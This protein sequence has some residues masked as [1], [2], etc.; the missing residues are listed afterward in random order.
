MRKLT[1][2]T[3]FLV[4]AAALFMAAPGKGLAQSL[5]LSPNQNPILLTI[6]GPGGT[7]AATYSVSA[8]NG[9]AVSSVFV[10]PI[11]TTTG[12]SWLSTSTPGTING[13][14]FTLN[15][16]NTTNLAPN[17]SYQGTVGVTASTTTGNITTTFP[18][19]L[20]IGNT[21]GQPGT[22]NG[23]L[24]NPS[25]I[26]F[27]ETAPGQASPSSQVVSVTLNG[28]QV[29]ITSVNFVTSPITTPTFINTQLNMQ[30]GTVTVTPNSV[31]TAAGTY[32]GTLTAYTASG[33]LPIPVVLCFGP[34]APTGGTGN[35][36]TATPN[37]L[38]F[39][40]QTGGSTAPQTVNINFNGAATNINSVTA[41]TNTGG[42]WL[43]P[44]STLPGT[45][46]VGVNA[47]GLTAGTYAG[48]VFVN[49]PQGQ[50]TIPVS[51]TVSG[52][53]SLT[54]TP[55][56]VNFAYQLGTNNPLSQTV[57]IASNGSAVSY[58]VSSTTTT[59][60]SQWLIVSPSGQGATPGTLTVSVQPSGLA[61]GS[62]YTG[63]IQ[64]NTFGGA[65]NGTI[66][67]PVSLLVSAS[68]I[69]AVNPTSLSFTAQAGATAPSQTFQITS[70]STALNYT[71]NASVTTPPAGTW[72]QVAT[73][74]G[75]TPSTVTVAVNTAGLAAGTYSGAI[76]ITSTN[77]GNGSVLV[78]V[79]LT[80]SAGAALQLTPGTLSFAY[81]LG[82]A[83]PANQSVT[84]ASQTGILGYTTAV[85]T[86]SGQN[87]LTVSPTTGTAP[88]NFVVSVVPAG[89]TA[90]TY[91]GTITVT[92]SGS[93]NAP[94][95]IPVTLVVS[96]T[97]LLLA[98]PNFV[99]FTAPQG[100]STSSFQ[101]VA[102]TSTD[103]T[104]IAF[105]VTSTTNSAANWLL[106]STSTG[107]TPANLTI[108]ANP[109]GL[110]P[111]T[112]TGTVTLTATT[113]ANVANSPQGITVTLVVT[114]TA[115][116]AVSQPTLSFTQ[117]TSGPAP[118]SQTVSVTSVGN[119]ITF[120]TNATVTA[121]GNWLSVTPINATTPAILTVTANGA[122]LGPGTYTGQITLTSPG[123][124]APQVISVTLTVAN[125]PTIAISPASLAAVN[126][127]VGGANP[128]AQTLAISATGGAAS[129]F[130]ATANTTSGGTWLSVTPT[131]A[132]TPANVTVNVN[133]SGLAA[134]TYTG[135]VSIAIA[136]ATNTPVIIPITL[137]VTPVAV[138]PPAIVAIQNAA[139]ST[140]SSISPGLNIVIYGSNMGPGTLATL[141]VG[142]NGLLQST[143]SGTQVT[144]D[145]IPAPLIYTKSTQVSVMVPYELTGRATTSMVVT[146]NGIASS[147]LVLRVVD[148][149]PGI[150][151]LNQTG[152]GQGAILNQNGTV[153]GPQNPEIV[154]NVLQIFAT[155][156]G[157]TLPAGVTGG[158]NPSRLPV[159]APILPVTVT[160]GGI[161]VP[162]KDVIYAGEAPGIVAGVLQVDATVPQGAGT[163]PVSV[164]IQ[165]G[166]ASS[167]S[168]VT[169]SLK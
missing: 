143:V 89:L 84:V 104:P 132:T 95:T 120:A 28:V 21:P 164:V 11:N 113:P 63:N 127:Q 29:P 168:N 134:G 80:I 116:L 53:P 8:S 97:S 90:G 110:A 16:G 152:S 52:T 72:L 107:T 2:F 158:I 58:T 34:C 156:E 43:L 24:S 114:P 92:A 33:I 151:T 135:S 45:I 73:Q 49:T 88:G 31:I 81:Q 44:S 10:S 91:Q 66:N 148:S 18:V 3:E 6:S 32:N 111:G 139:S 133:P 141:Q 48:T 163:G 69:L 36:L 109:S 4:F 161:P 125:A 30:A 55:T 169:V 155:G 142:S 68:P 146:Y 137:T 126:F 167:Q 98:S 7:A 13:N 59:G 64:I 112:Y 138:V 140:P 40:L 106:V 157:Q 160:I 82:Q 65:T 57:S 61:S 100:S 12:G 103:Q 54:A 35:G 153:N 75:T 131:T 149:A 105:N 38:S 37:P 115:T 165:V 128:T 74:S 124:A 150:Y 96:S 9:S 67:I 56:A 62:T 101:N 147:P 42:T 22:S 166:G 39:Q 27:S 20:Q 23:L 86:N 83:Q 70:S 79:T 60:G 121:G 108:S 41:T 159:P 51:L 117:S 102:L 123:A 136:G 1:R 85:T 77:S 119:A 46:S 87:W 145:G 19:T 130:T 71:L 129:T 144:F 99:S 122:N 94:Q 17:S 78:P 14:Q 15:V 5:I 76:N 118:N 26:T 50:I 162:A 25:T 154:G 47:S 93:N